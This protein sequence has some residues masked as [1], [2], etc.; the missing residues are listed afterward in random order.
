MGEGLPHRCRGC[1]GTRNHW[2]H[3]DEGLDGQCKRLGSC[4]DLTMGGERDRGSAWS[5]GC[6]GDHPGGCIDTQPRRQVGGT[7]SGRRI[8]SRNVVGEG[9]P[10][11]CRGCRG[12][13]NR[14]SLTWRC[15]DVSRAGIVCGLVGDGIDARGAAGI[16]I[17]PDDHRA[18]R[19]GHRRAE[20]VSRPRFADNEKGLLPPRRP[21]LHEQVRPNGNRVA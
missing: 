6:A 4:A 2:D 11:R 20:I 16:C 1:R 13:R 18:T 8:A 12:T 9:L 17:G 10:H 7:I 3:Q 21:V 19:H 15:V 5:R 14:R